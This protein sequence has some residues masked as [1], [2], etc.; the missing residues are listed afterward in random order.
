M[1]KNK[2][3]RILILF[4]L[5]FHIV[6][7]QNID[8]KILKTINGKDRPVW[9]KI[10]EGISFSA[11]PAMPLTI[12]GVWVYG[13]RNDDN[14][15]MRNAYKTTI[16]ITLANSISLGMKAGFKRER[17]FVTYPNEITQR[18]H[19]GPLSFPSG[20]TTAAFATATSLSLSVKKWEIAV[21]AY[22]YAGLVGYS[23]MRLGVH[24]PSDVLAGALIGI[25]S[26]LLVWKIDK[27][28]RK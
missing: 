4:F 25:G 7:C 1:I 14:E 27:L 3:Y 13:F 23:R 18:T 28:I 15:M 17:P 20:H 21:P 2:A 9:D 5:L 6:N 16:A 22:L 19:A 10:N 24:Y 26:G 12:G 11:Y 8:Y